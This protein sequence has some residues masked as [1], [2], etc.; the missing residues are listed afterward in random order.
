MALFLYTFPIPNDEGNGIFEKH[1]FLEGDKCPTRAEMLDILKKIDRQHEKENKGTFA[2]GWET[3]PHKCIECLK[4]VEAEDWPVCIPGH[5]IMTNTF[6][7]TEF[8][9]QAISCQII[10]PFKID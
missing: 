1:I 7:D 10:E 4:S 2:E 9:R 8:G 3:E 6:C 5:L